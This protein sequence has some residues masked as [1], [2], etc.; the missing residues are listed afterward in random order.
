MICLIDSF[1]LSW[2]A[3][4]S[5]KAHDGLWLKQC[6][7]FPE[8]VP[9][10]TTAP[11]GWK[12]A[13]CPCS[14]GGDRTVNHSVS[15]SFTRSVH[16]AAS[17]HLQ[18]TTPLRTVIH[19]VPQTNES[20]LRTCQKHVSGW[21]RRQPPQLICVTL[22]ASQH[23]HTERHRTHHR[24]YGVFLSL[25]IFSSHTYKHPKWHRKLIT[26]LH[27]EDAGLEA[28]WVAMLEDTRTCRLQKS[29][30]EQP[31]YY[32]HT[33]HS[34]DDIIWP[35][36]DLYQEAIIEGYSQDEVTRCSDQK[37]VPLALWYS[38]DGSILIWDL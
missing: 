4:L 21:M 31:L 12:S 2:P 3:V 1:L 5:E 7:N 25:W 19:R 17:S 33:I 9:M 35:H 14:W 38:S 24:L 15:H 13:Q 11:L 18:C 32:R 36:L 6:T 28:G 8:C 27:S 23:Q 29:R 16:W 34:D 30:I 37:L 20:V 22:N 26:H 10:A